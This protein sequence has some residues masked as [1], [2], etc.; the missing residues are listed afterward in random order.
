MREYLSAHTPADE[1]PYPQFVNFSVEGD[2]VVISVR[3]KQTEVDGVRICGQ[4]CQPGG[5]GCNNYC[6]MA[7]DKGPMADKP[8]D[9]THHNVGAQAEMR[10][11]RETAIQIMGEALAKLMGEK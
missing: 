9:F 5:F 8:E 10:L 2:E 3:A 4:T 1:R 7:P 6:N 11:P